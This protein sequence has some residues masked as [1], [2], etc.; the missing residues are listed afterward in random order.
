MKGKLHDVFHVSLLEP[1]TENTI[2]GQ[3][4]PPLPPINDDL[5]EYIAEDIIDSRVRGKGK[6]QQVEYLVEWSGYG[7]DDRTWEPYENLLTADGD[8][9]LLDEFHRKYP[10]KPRDKRIKL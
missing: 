1:Y 10:S 7:P 6:S 8:T 4:T 9:P 5:D 2:P 3:A